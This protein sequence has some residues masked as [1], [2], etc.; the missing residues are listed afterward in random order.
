MIVK[1]TIILLMSYLSIIIIDT[2]FFDLLLCAAIS[3]PW[4]AFVLHLIVLSCLEI[5][6]ITHLACIILYNLLYHFYIY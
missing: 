1:H 3:L 5:A 6:T 4:M 2:I